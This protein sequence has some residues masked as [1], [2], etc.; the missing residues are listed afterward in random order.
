MNFETTPQ[1]WFNHISQEINTNALL[2]FV[3][4]SNDKINY[5]IL[6]KAVN[7]LIIEDPILGCIF[8]ENF[9]PPVWQYE[10]KN[11]K[12]PCF[13]LQTEDMTSKIKEILEIEIDTTKELPLCVYLLE[14]KINNTIILKV[15]H[16]VC[17]GSGIKYILKQ[18][19]T[20][21]TQIENHEK[22]ESSLNTNNR[23][24]N[25]FYRSFNIENIN[26]YFEAEKAETPPTWGFPINKSNNSKLFTFKL[27][28]YSKDDFNKIKEFS[29]LNEITINSLFCAIYFKALVQ[30]LKIKDQNKELQ[31]M[32]DLRKYLDKERPQTICNLATTLN[33][34]LSTKFKNYKNY[35]KYTD[36]EIKN[37]INSKDFI[38]NTIA[39]DLSKDLGYSKLKDAFITEWDEIK[40]TESCTPMIT[41]LGLFDKNTIK[42][43]SSTI[44]DIYFISP[45]FVAPA[46]MLSLFTYNNTISI[47]SSYYEE[48][49]S[50]KIINNLFN[51]MEIQI[52]ELLIK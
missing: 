28:R 39:G 5:E 48:N 3:I 9:N 52:K 8:N 7:Y 37:L 35:F 11:F 1:D 12:T 6:Y 30:T 25:N 44:S 22:K 19:S 42:F 33:V 10:F 50:S 40:N 24:T 31:F 18:L 21:Y 46:F 14:N 20:I 51:N 41:N 23:N 2:Q 43:G 13:I 36:N 45:A 49:I 27:L 34:K 32:I 15:N 17:D 16:S 29:K 4:Q 26:S 47:C 38:H